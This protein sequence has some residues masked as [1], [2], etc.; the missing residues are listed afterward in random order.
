M[1]FVCGVIGGVLAKLVLDWW[2]DERHHANI[3]LSD[4]ELRRLQALIYQRYPRW[5]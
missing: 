4:V 1:S 5:Q 3:G 2:R